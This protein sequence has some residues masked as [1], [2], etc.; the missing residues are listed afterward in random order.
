MGR[1]V[2]ELRSDDGAG[3]DDDEQRGPQGF[4]KPIPA[5][6]AEVLQDSKTQKVGCGL[7]DGVKQEPGGDRERWIEPREGH[8]LTIVSGR[9]GL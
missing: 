5:P 1:V 9:G 3:D 6:A 4:G 2:E 8:G 7:K